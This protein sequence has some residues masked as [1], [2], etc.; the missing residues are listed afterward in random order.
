MNDERGTMNDERGTMNDERGRMNRDDDPLDR[1]IDFSKAL[2][3]PYFVAYHGPKVIRVLDADLAEV[4]PDN[5]SV[6]EA[7]RALL[8]LTGEVATRNDEG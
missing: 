3:N 8:R 1:E 7:L 2:P 4:F 6:N 5:A